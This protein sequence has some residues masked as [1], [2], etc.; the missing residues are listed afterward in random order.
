MHIIT[1]TALSVHSVVVV[2][3]LISVH[4]DGELIFILAALLIMTL[5]QINKNN[6]TIKLQKIG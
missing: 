2:K 4:S 1:R 3:P 5:N 6:W